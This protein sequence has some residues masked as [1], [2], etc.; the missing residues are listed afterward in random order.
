MA[1]VKPKLNVVDYTAL[2]D[3]LNKVLVNENTVW[4]LVGPCTTSHNFAGQ[5][6]NKP[7]TGD[8]QFF[9]KQVRSG[10]K[11]PLFAFQPVDSRPYDY[12]EFPN[13]KVCDLIKGFQHELLKAINCSETG[14]TWKHASAV[15]M[16]NEFENRAK[17]K[18]EVEKGKY[19][20]D[21]L[22]GSF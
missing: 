11:G 13:D 15:W 18:E 5:W 8:E 1:P 6:K 4:S 16:A 9:L 14:A 12:V 7:L 21:P 10:S 17:A 22:W 19:E 2:I 3:H 20:G